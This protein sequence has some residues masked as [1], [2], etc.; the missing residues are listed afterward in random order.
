MKRSTGICAGIVIASL[1]I[2]VVPGLAE[3]LQWRREEPVSFRWLTC[4]LAHWSWNHF[5]WDIVAFIALAI[6]AVRLAP[7]RIDICVVAAMLAIPVEISLFQ[8]EFETYRGLSGIDSALF[9]LI[10]ISLWYRGSLA[11]T[12][13]LLAG[14]LFL[15]KTVFEVMT[16]NALF[17]NQG[18]VDFVPVA[19]AHLVGAICGLITGLT[20]RLQASHP[21]RLLH[22]TT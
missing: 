2:Q 22:E 4:H 9:G 3:N 19:S 21:D 8:P 12:M 18:T 20:T 7:T 13:A 16:G 5:V 6:A 17:A 11:R 1:I 15:G 14:S 10:V